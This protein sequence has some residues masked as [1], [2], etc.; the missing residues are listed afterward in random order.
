[1]SAEGLDL[2]KKSRGPTAYGS[3]LWLPC[4]SDHNKVYLAFSCA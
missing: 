1:M 2:V 4:F 3:Q